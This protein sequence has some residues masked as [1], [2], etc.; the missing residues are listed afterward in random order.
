MIIE[1]YKDTN[2][3]VYLMLKRIPN[4][5]IEDKALKNLYYI[6]NNGKII[7]T[8]AYELHKENAI[9][10]YFIYN[11]LMDILDLEKL[12]CKIEEDAKEKE[13]ERLINITNLDDIINKFI[14]FGYQEID[15]ELVIIDEM[16]IP[17]TIYKDYKIYVKK[18]K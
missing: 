16:P 4:L 13:I 8:L 2:D 11:K 18:I 1:K 14:Y 15:N 9:I 7:A 12:H 17:C 3:D 10:R 5:Y 6:K